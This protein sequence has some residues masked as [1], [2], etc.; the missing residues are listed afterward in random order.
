VAKNQ[1]EWFIPVR[2]HVKSKRSNAKDTT[3]AT[4]TIEIV[5]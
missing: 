4:E 1:N 2:E 3:G 5:E